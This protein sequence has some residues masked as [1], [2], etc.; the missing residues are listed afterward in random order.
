[1][2]EQTTPKSR[3][4]WYLWVIPIVLLVAAAAAGV[5]WFVLRPPKQP[6]IV[7]ISL[8]SV[9]AD[10]LGC[11]GY[12]RPTSPA[13]DALAEE[14][15]VYDDAHAVTSWTLPTHASLFTGLYP[16]AHQVIGSLGR[17]DKSYTTLAEILTE[18]GYHCGGVISGPYLREAHGLNQGFAWYDEATSSPSQAL[19]HTEVTCPRME[20]GLQNFLTRIRER[21]RPFFLFA[22]FWDPHYDYIPPA[23]YD[24]MFVTEECES[25]D[26]T[27][28]EQGGAVTEGITPGQLAYV[29]SQYDGEIRWTDDHLQRFFR[30]LK[31]EG[32]WDDTA[33]I[34]L[35]DH[36]EEFFEHHA[37][38]HKNN[39]YTESIRIPLIMKYPGGRPRGR[40]GRLVS[41]VDLFPTVLELAGASGDEVHQG[42][43]LLQPAR[44]ANQPIYFDLT[45]T[46]YSP[47]RG[48]G[49][50]PHYIRH[51]LGVRQ[52]DYAL[53][54]L[55]EDQATEL[56]HVSEDPG[57]RVNLFPAEAPRAGELMALIRQSQEQNQALARVLE[58]SGEAELSEEALKTLRALGYLK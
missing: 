31:R 50:Q 11:Y 43:S 36:G 26:V 55:V 34:V 19:A 16:N 21:W 54:H 46:R 39:L 37:K 4:R 47:K 40:N 28:Y 12:E 53:I 10:H 32:L 1:M 27:N 5:W 18:Y 42:H 8:E 35:S 2:N 7:L 22:Y 30:L 45:H 38:G 6:N 56:Y 41:Q 52:A 14:S 23:P 20:A 51:W 17:L 58:A 57:Q 15:V 44:P 13:L 3:Q 48:G 29:I 25:L 33:I 49:W 9:R 24:R